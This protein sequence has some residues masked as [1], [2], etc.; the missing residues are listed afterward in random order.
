MFSNELAAQGVIQNAVIFEQKCLKKKR[1][2]LLL[3][4]LLAMVVTP[5]M[6]PFAVIAM[7]INKLS[8]RFLALSV[9]G[10]M[11]SIVILPLI[12]ISLPKFATI[13]MWY[14]SQTYELF[15]GEKLKVADNNGELYEF[16]EERYESWIRQAI[17]SSK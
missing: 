2:S 8:L 10:F 1:I 7:G 9:H 5:V 6:V 12:F 15:K 16:N 14:S 3:G 13:S 4:T 17:A 11:C